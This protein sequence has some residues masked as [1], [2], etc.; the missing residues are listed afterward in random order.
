MCTAISAAVSYRY[1]R[2][3]SRRARGSA[4]PT[5]LARRGPQEGPGLKKKRDSSS[6]RSVAHGCHTD[7]HT[8]YQ[9]YVSLARSQ[10]RR[11]AGRPHRAGLVCVA[12]VM[13]GKLSEFT[14]VLYMT[15]VYREQRGPR[16]LLG[17]T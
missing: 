14:S 9:V 11:L 10:A 8:R 6:I 16:P 4:S 5:L 2:I 3:A 15:R 1:C 7:Y 12:L 17:A 13:T